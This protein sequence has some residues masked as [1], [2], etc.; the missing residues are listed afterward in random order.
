MLRN[1][2]IILT[3]IITLYTGNVYIADRDNNRIRFVSASTGNITTI[4]GNGNNGYNNGDGGPATAALLNRPY[5]VA[6]D[7]S[8]RST[9]LHGLV[10]EVIILK[11]II[12]T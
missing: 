5:D 6:V 3:V 7:S 1:I 4:A 12:L 10:R 2:V 8:G 11:I 9:F